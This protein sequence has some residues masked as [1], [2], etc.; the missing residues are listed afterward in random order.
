MIDKKT[1]ENIKDLS[2]F[3]DS[4]LKF[5]QL[6]MTI[7]S[8]SLLTKEDES[9]FFE[10]KELVSKRY[11]ALKDKME[12]KYM[13][14]SRLTDPVHEIL[15]LDGIS[16]MSE[17][18]SRRIDDDWRD[19]YIFLNSILE[20]LKNRKKRLEHFSTIGVWVKRMFERIGEL[21]TQS[22]P[23]KADPPQA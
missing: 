17:K 4:W 21:K 3:M 15:G 23:P 14:Y 2:G 7:C 13:P 5:R 10:T 16:C 9:I 8:K 22:V 6:Y 19:S 12:F 11:A 18:K 20:R 1:E